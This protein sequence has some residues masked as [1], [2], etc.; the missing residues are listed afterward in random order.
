MNDGQMHETI[1]GLYQGVFE[2]GAWQRSL[3]A[4]CD[5]SGSSQASLVVRNRALD[6]VVVTH[7]VDYKPD[8]MEA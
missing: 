1:R 6:R 4:L 8:A 5:A 3:V 2:T 7:A